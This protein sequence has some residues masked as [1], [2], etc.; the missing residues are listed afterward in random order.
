[1]GIWLERIRYHDAVVCLLIPVSNTPD[2]HAFVAR[3]LNIAGMKRI[4]L[5][6]Q[7]VNRGN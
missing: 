5:V 3:L 2:I 7:G 6:L 1:M 4:A